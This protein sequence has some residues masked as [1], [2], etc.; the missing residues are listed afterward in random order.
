MPDER[1]DDEQENKIGKVDINLGAESPKDAATRPEMPLRVLVLGDF[2][3]DSPE[4]EDWEASSRLIGVT[5]RDFESVMQ[6]LEPRLIM[7]VPNCL[8]ESP[9]ELTVELSFTDMKSNST[10]VRSVRRVL[11]LSPAEPRLLVP[12]VPREVLRWPRR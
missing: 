8:S 1:Q 10:L 6:Q 2:A 3:P 9:K 11:S 12:M 7:D 5:P 4:V